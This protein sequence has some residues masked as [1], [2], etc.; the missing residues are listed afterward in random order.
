MAMDDDRRRCVHA[1]AVISDMA[2]DLDPNGCGEPDRDGVRAVRV[3]HPPGML[4]V[5]GANPVQPLVQLPDRAL[6][7]IDLN[8]WRCQE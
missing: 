5:S 7:E 3:Y 1:R 4:I 8:H 2:V 6:G